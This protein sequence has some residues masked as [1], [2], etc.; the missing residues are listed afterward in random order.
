MTIHSLAADIA[1]R[2][3]G[4]AK[5][6]KHNNATTIEG[7]LENA[8][9]RFDRRALP[10]EIYCLT[11]ERMDKLKELAPVSVILEEMKKEDAFFNL[12]LNGDRERCYDVFYQSRITATILSEIIWAL[13]NKAGGEVRLSLSDLAPVHW[14]MEE[15]YD[16]ATKEKVFK[17]IRT[18]QAHSDKP[19]PNIRDFRSVD[20]ES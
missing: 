14:S 1:D 8:G 12:L 16:E 9:V 17:T 4:M 18:D 7:M 19:A 6:M 13:V 15:F 11:K 10:P 3:E 2:I 5:D 20:R